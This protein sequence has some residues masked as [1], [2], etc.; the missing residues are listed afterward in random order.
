M[1]QG[2]EKYYS[3]RNL[4]FMLFEVLDMHSLTRHEYF[5]A[6]NEESMN[7]VLDA[8]EN[9]AEKIMRPVFVESDRNPPELTNGGVKVHKSIGDYYKAFCDAGLMAASFDH[10][11]GGQQLPRTVYAAADFIL[12]SA[13]N[14]FEMFTSLSNSAARLLAGFACPHLLDEYTIKILEGKYAATM[15]LTETGA[16]SSLSDIVTEAQIDSDGLY[17]IKGQKIFISAGDHDITENII[18]LVLARVRGAVKGVKGISLF[19]VP[20]KKRS[21][22]PW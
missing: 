10:G 3:R 13:H 22:D 15:C 9:I 5:S 4:N 11:I 17:K 21:M 6:H 18:H 12:G 14:G 2:K 7:M 20:K 1:N 16:G 8:A 19:L